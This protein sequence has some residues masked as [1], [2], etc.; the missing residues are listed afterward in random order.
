MKRKIIASI[1]AKNQRGLNQRLNKVRKNV[2]FFQLDVMD[3]KF[4]R[5]KSFMFN[6]KIPKGNYEAHLMMFNPEKWI[7]KSYKKVHTIIFHVEAVKN[8]DE[9]INLIKSKKKKVGIAINPKTHVK[10]IKPYLNKVDL[11]LVMCVNP[12]KYGSKFIPATLKKVKELRKLKP[13]FNIEVDGGLG[14]EHTGEAKKAGAN[15]FISGSYL[16]NTDD[17]GK[18]VRELRRRII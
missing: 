18:A 14:L 7:E 9:V 17:V 10:K 15:L 1:I 3:G 12:G 2:K 16:Q 13:K 4:V 8:P 5:N 11:V 6:F